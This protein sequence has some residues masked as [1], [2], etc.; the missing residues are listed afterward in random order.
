[1]SLTNSKSNE[2]DP[3]IYS[4]TVLHSDTTSMDS[5]DDSPS[6][7][8]SLD[9]NKNDLIDEQLD[10][11]DQGDDVL[12]D[13]QGNT[14]GDE[15]VDDEVPS[16]EMTLTT[17]VE[18]QDTEL[19]SE[20]M[21]AEEEIREDNSTTNSVINEVAD[22][23]ES[24]VV[25]EGQAENNDG[26]STIV[27]GDVSN[28]VNEDQTPIMSDIN[29]PSEH[30]SM[31]YKRLISITPLP[32]SLMTIG[33]DSYMIMQK[34]IIKCVNIPWLVKRCCEI[35]LAKGLELVGIF[36][37]PGN[38]HETEEI[39]DSFNEGF[40]PDF[41]LYD[42]ES[43]A[44]ALKKYL[45]GLPR[46]LLSDDTL[47]DVIQNRVVS[48]M[49]LED[50][51]DMIVQLKEVVES[52]TVFHHSLLKEFFYLLY[53]ISLHEETNMMH[54][55]NLATIFGGMVDIVSNI[56]P[57]GKKTDL[58][59]LMISHYEDIFG[60]HNYLP[61]SL[62]EGKSAKGVYIYL[63]DG[64]YSS[65]IS[66]PQE[67][68]QDTLLYIIGKQYLIKPEILSNSSFLY[69]LKDTIWRRIEPDEYIVPISERGSYILLSHLIDPDLDNGIDLSNYVAQEP[70]V[71]NQ[72]KE[73]P[74]MIR[75]LSD[76][77]VSNTST[78]SIVA[79]DELHRT[80]STD[81]IDQVKGRKRFGSARRLSIADFLTGGKKKSK[82]R[83]TSFDDTENIEDLKTI[84]Q[85]YIVGLQELIDEV[86]NP[87]CD[88]DA[89]DPIIAKLKKT[90][91][92]IKMLHESL[93]ESFEGS[94]NIPDTFTE[95]SFDFIFYE[96]YYKQKLDFDI[97]IRALSEKPT[98]MEITI[99]DVFDRINLPVLHIAD[100]H[101]F[102]QGIQTA[103]ES[104]DQKI[105][106]QKCLEQVREIQEYFTLPEID[107]KTRSVEVSFSDLNMS[108]QHPNRK[109]IK[110]GSM[111]W[112][113]DKKRQVAVYLFTDILLIGTKTEKERVNL[114]FNSIFFLKTIEIDL[115]EK[116][117][118]I[119]SPQQ[120]EPIVL[121][122]PDESVL[123]Q[124]VID[125][126]SAVTKSKETKFAKPAKRN[127]SKSK[128]TNSSLLRRASESNH[129]KVP[130]SRTSRRKSS[131]HRVKRED[132][133]QFPSP[134]LSLSKYDLWE[135][136][137]K[138]PEEGIIPQGSK[139]SK[140]SGK[141][142]IDWLIEREYAHDRDTAINMLNDFLKRKGINPVQKKEDK[143]TDSET[144]YYRFAK[145]SR[146]IPNPS[147][148]FADSELW[149]I[150]VVSYEGCSQL[151][152]LVEKVKDI[153]HI[154]LE[155]EEK[156]SKEDYFRWLC[157]NRTQFHKKAVLHHSSPFLYSKHSRK[158]LGDLKKLLDSLE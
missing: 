37:V 23:V 106:Y 46:P 14:D 91:E 44:S 116:C 103:C 99:L 72:E 71:Y 16:E 101:H 58:C 2:V 132:L 53:R 20:D 69:E 151:Q 93:I 61:P 142:A 43:I 144:S 5:S 124:W 118:N 42:T 158:Y 126:N 135:F 102:F 11:D 140:W 111:Y 35:L 133:T 22:S 153:D 78:P 52:L 107:E 63:Q 26:D 18:N 125:I 48:I 3:P 113:S 67:K 60:E 12:I 59:N 96:R 95:K 34:N 80:K 100:Y 38:H 21:H 143:I 33:L 83:K 114:L 51:E 64:T 149:K 39:L 40:E 84:E 105:E 8:T 123:R 148:V 1:M 127:R 24:L 122:Y 112:F 86:L 4:D 10:S 88:S 120:N 9:E 119:T 155:V 31:F 27:P 19:L 29:D 89:N 147:E 154:K 137:F 136:Y 139:S 76:R 36:R 25:N 47:E 15:Q 138:D 13:G 28:D 56:L 85:E 110:E 45:R 92:A 94:N 90:T 141:K 145:I 6:E 79:D 32:R 70:T 57:S 7:L 74:S 115:V 82:K 81:R 17:D 134:T 117:I 54:S 41:S 30:I 131:R 104:I 50:E 77:D 65:K 68:A 130:S 66:R 156:N 73:S 109:L 87:L 128:L 108:L 121:G 129:I 146:R 152:E 97:L 150:C 62:E 157:S 49:E 98:V 55:Y 75:P